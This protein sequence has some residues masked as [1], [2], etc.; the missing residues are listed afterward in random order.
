[1]EYTIE[2]FGNPDLFNVEIKT[3]H[4]KLRY[5]FNPYFENQKSLRAKCAD[6]ITKLKEN[7]GEHKY[8]FNNVLYIVKPDVISI[9]LSDC[10]AGYMTIELPITID[11]I[12]FYENMMND[13]I[14]K[15]R[16]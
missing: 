7:V 14:S 10:E 13:Y 12:S 3:P 2:R 15:E 8:E 5:N 4:I 11:F 6:F 9:T 16:N 1:M